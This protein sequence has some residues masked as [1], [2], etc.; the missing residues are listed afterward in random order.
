MVKINS[1]IGKMTIKAK[2]A[3]TL[4]VV[5]QEEDVSSEP[6]CGIAW[7]YS[8]KDTNRAE[9]S[10]SE[11]EFSDILAKGVVDDRAGRLYQDWAGR[12]YMEKEDYP[13]LEQVSLQPNLSIPLKSR[14]N[15]KC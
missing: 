15:L 7:M 5:E 8:D 6:T 9:D 4:P 3:G 14:P 10:I 13:G 12:L 11:S 2:K 1:K